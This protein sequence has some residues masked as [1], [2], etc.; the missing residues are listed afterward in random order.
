M[1][2]ALRIIGITECAQQLHAARHIVLTTH[3]NPD[4]DAIGSESALYEALTAAGKDVR[5]INCDVLPENLNFLNEGDTVETY[6]PATHDSVFASAD[7]LVAMDFNDIRRIRQMGESFRSSAARKLVIDHHLDPKTFADYYCSIPEA[8]STSEIVYDILELNGSPLTQ[9]IARGLYV[10]IMTDTGSFRFDRTTPRVHRIAARLLEAG[11]DP[12]QIHRLIFD[13]YPLSRTQLLGM[14]LAGIDRHCDGRVSLL[15][16][17]KEMFSRTGTTMEDVENIVNS[18]L[19]IRG[20]EA[21]ALL[22]EFDD[23][24]KVSFRSRGGISVNDIA[25]QFGGGGHRLASGATVVGVPIAE[26]KERV[27]AALCAALKK[28]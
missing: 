16:V 24:I 19:S 10:G 21:T 26:L 18:G 20:V 23:Q 6:D 9:A 8:S 11:V 12:T 25:G 28:E 15:T 14:I 22:T 7:M 27:A 1:S 5:I 3:T 13:D 2:D 4:G 17:T